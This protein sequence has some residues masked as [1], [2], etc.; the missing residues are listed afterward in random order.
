MQVMS[1]T[2]QI[3]LLHIF[4]ELKTV[5]FYFLKNR[6][7]VP[8]LLKD[9]FQWPCSIRYACKVVKATKATATFPS[10][11]FPRLLGGCRVDD[12]DRIQWK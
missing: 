9:V 6:V 12:M 10:F 11:P 3:L 2:D 7:E 1:S 8:N 5:R 4:L